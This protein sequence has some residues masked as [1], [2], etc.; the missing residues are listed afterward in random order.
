MRSTDFKDTDEIKNIWGK[1]LAFSINNDN[2]PVLY[3]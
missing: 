2:N 1:T 3:Y